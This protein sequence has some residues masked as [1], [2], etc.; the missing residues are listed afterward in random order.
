[1]AKRNEKK[2]KQ[3]R[4]VKYIYQKSKC[5]CNFAIGLPGAWNKQKLLKTV[6]Q[7]DGCCL[8]YEDGKSVVPT[9]WA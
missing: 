8:T 9:V 2:K 4:N 7:F 1:M 6:K 5:N 3:L